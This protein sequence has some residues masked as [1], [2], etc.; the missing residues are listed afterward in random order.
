MF[1]HRGLANQQGFQFSCMEFVSSVLHLHSMTM[2]AGRQHGFLAV[3][4]VYRKIEWFSSGQE[5]WVLKL[6][7]YMD[8]SK[9]FTHSYSCSWSSCVALS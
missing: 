5:N 2:T 1:G 6:R 7:H 8:F 9:I 4:R 3:Q